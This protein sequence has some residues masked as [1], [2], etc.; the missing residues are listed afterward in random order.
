MHNQPHLQQHSA[1]GLRSF[2]VSRQPRSGHLK[3][4]SVG[5]SARN[6]GTRTWLQQRIRD[7]FLAKFFCHETQMTDYNDSFSYLNSF[8]YL[9]FDTVSLVVLAHGP[10]AARAL[11][12]A[13]ELEPEAPIKIIAAGEFG[14]LLW[15]RRCL[16][17]ATELA[18][19]HLQAAQHNEFTPFAANASALHDSFQRLLSPGNWRS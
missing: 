13:D 8:S 12:N 1:A 18:L 9:A 6:F 3:N 10:T 11:E 15:T 4:L 19:R 14:H 2:G 16:L 17:P 5:G 7:E